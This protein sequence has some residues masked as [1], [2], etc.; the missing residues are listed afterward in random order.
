MTKFS[1]DAEQLWV[2]QY[3]TED[4]SH[5][6]FMDI[7]EEIRIRVIDEEFVDLTPEGPAPPTLDGEAKSL[8]I[9]KAPYTITVSTSGVFYK[10]SSLRFWF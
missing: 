5:D 10:L 3:E 7:N 1:V 2:W 8:E 6:L 9:K 4:G